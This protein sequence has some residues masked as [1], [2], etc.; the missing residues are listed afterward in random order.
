[1]PLPTA[2]NRRKVVATMKK[3][4]NDNPLAPVR[5]TYV[6]INSEARRDGQPSVPTF[7]SV[8]TILKR[9]KSVKLPPLPN[10]QFVRLSILPRK[11]EK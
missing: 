5:A 3:R 2:I 6:D 10:R 4:I 8:R 1:M 7:D 11:I 9:Q